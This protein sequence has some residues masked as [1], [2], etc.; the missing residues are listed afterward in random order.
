MVM[1]PE[2]IGR[3]E[4]LE[5]IGR[6][7]MAAVYRALDPNFKREVAI[8]LLPAKFLSDP[9]FRSRFDRE[10]HTIAQLEHPTIV[11]VYDYGEDQEQPYLVM[12]LMPGRSLAERLANGPLPVQSTI[13]ILKRL[14][15]GLDFAHQKGVIH[16]D[17][18]PG[19]IL[20]DQPGNPYLS[21]FGIAKLTGSKSV[22]TD[23][24][25][26]GTPAYISPEQGLGEAKI[27]YRSDLYSLGVMVFEMLTGRLPFEAAAATDQIL[28]HISQPVP[29]L[30][31]INPTLPEALQPVIERM[32]D[33]NPDRR[34]LS[35]AEMVTALAAAANLS[36]TIP[37]PGAVFP[38]PGTTPGPS[39]TSTPPPTPGRLPALRST[40]A[41]GVHRTPTPQ[42]LRR[43]TPPSGASVNKPGLSWLPGLVVAILAVAALALA[44]L[45]FWPELSQGLGAPTS[46]PA[47]VVDAEGIAESLSE[48][49]GSA[50]SLSLV[51][52]TVHPPTSTPELKPTSTPPPPTF[53]P[54][55][56]EPA[57]GAAT[58][59]PAPD[60]PVL[61]GADRLAFVRNNVIY[62]MNLDGSDFEVVLERGGN[63]FGLQWVPDGRSISY[64]TGKCVERVDVENRRQES[65]FCANWANSLDAFEISP[66]G[67]YVAI[68]LSDG[69]FILPY[70]EVYLSQIN[71]PE[72]LSGSLTC[73]VYKQNKT[74]A[75]RWAMDNSQL[76]AI[77]DT[78][79]SRG[80]QVELVRLLR[81][82]GCGQPLTLA[83]EIP[84]KRFEMNE[85]E[86]RPLIASFGF[87]GSTIL[88]LNI[89]RLNG[90]GQ[91]YEYQTTTSKVQELY[92]LGVDS[93]LGTRCCFRD[94][95]WSP[96][97]DYLLFT[98][99][100]YNVGRGMSFY[101]VKYGTM[102]TGEIYTP[103]PLPTEL[104]GSLR[105]E[106]LEPV[107][108]RA[109]TP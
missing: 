97:G 11:P 5:L 22:L 29:R 106:R 73:V 90:F 16:R 56:S 87:D 52:S 85:Y 100:D 17:L 99:Q 24:A 78:T 38:N 96:D 7:G 81:F 8:K 94:Y 65:I 34:Y 12:R 33:K 20:F 46:P 2:K 14:A 76:A 66:D 63:K 70:D 39:G 82:N 53:T 27:D 50:A 89:D 18:K 92:L 91:V 59:T 26:I 48:L 54:Q 49:A 108:R 64:I 44:G 51:T 43:D 67:Q 9:T 71:K 41:P 58:V 95:R 103:L 25:V 86:G 37:A 6:G 45:V 104:A 88:S 21:D 105:D 31:D 28:K 57:A 32:M 1:D 55:A 15:D 72:Q 101:Y 79:D 68:S 61:G 107:L 13:Q 47:A 98:F 69:L 75:V 40:P 109:L 19:N 35:A 36:N 93:Q 74:K 62:A 80:R 42:P 10:A 30:L 84:G 4:I 60:R 23:G 83:D 77:V 102:G 3:Y